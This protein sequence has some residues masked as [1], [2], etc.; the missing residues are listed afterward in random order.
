MVRLRFLHTSLPL[1]IVE[2]LEH[3]GE[4]LLRIVCHVGE[5]SALTV[6]QE[7]SA[8][9]GHIWHLGDL[10]VRIRPAKDIGN[11]QVQ[12][13][14]IQILY[15][16]QQKTAR[17]LRSRNRAHPDITDGPRGPEPVRKAPPAVALTLR[18]RGTS[19]QEVGDRGV[20][21]GPAD[22]GMIKFAADW[23]FPA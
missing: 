20:W 2:K 6:F 11:L 3:L 8:G 15:V 7:L 18:S 10:V 17:A 16:K 13:S 12:K 5:R 4:R 19:A 21:Q 1:V 22:G 23:C 9:D 14:H